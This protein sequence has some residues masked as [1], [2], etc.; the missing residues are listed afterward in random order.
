MQY[1][2]LVTYPNPILRK[3][4]NL[5]GEITPEIEE[6]ISHMKTVMQQHNGIGLAAPQV[7]APLQLFI[8]QEEDEVRAFLNPQI[9]SSSKEQETDTEGCLS[10]PKLWVEVSRPHAIT[11]SCLTP[12]GKEISLSLEGFS[13]RVF[14]HEIDHLN[15]ILIINRIPFWKRWKALRKYKSSS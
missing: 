8:V 14:Q 4:A 12:K 5:V 7:G 11:V 13:A 6:L 3:K 15:G 2:P 1:H 9:L 10:I